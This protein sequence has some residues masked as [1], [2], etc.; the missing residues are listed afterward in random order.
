M[1]AA[2]AN[3][4]DGIRTECGGSLVCATCHVHVDEA[5]CGKVGSADEIEEDMP[6][7]AETEQGPGSR[8]VC[9]I[10]GAEVLD[11]MTVFVPAA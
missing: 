3:D 8:L 5:S 1:E 9:Q 4:I 6:E 7:F 2:I 11:G 10:K